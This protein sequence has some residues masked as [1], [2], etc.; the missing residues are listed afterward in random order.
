MNG[1][2]NRGLTQTPTSSDLSFFFFIFLSPADQA[3][4]CLYTICVCALPAN[5]VQNILNMAIGLAIHIDHAT[6]LP[7][8]GWHTISSL[9]LHI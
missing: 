1:G 4:F 7:A 3:I 6:I 5:G 8:F 9:F 2:I